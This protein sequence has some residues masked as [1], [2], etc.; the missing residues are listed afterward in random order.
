MPFSLIRILHYRLDRRHQNLRWLNVAHFF[1]KVASQLMS[2]YLPLFLYQLAQEWEPVDR[3]IVFGDTP[4]Q[5]G[6][7]MVSGFFLIERLTVLGLAIP[8]AKLAS[9]IGHSRRMIL[10]NLFLALSVMLLTYVRSHPWLLTLSAVVSGF[11]ICFFW[12]SYHTVITRS[13]SK[14]KLGRNLGATRFLSNFALMLVPLI[15][16]IAVTSLGYEYLFYLGVLMILISVTALLYL[17]LKP[18]KDEISWKE[19]RTWLKEK[20]FEQLVVSQAG[21][22]FNDMAIIIW[23]LYVFLLLG[24]VAR[25]GLVY[26][27]SLFV[28]MII[29]LFVGGFIDRSKNKKR[30]LFISGGLLSAV[31]ALRILTGQIWTIVFVDSLDRIIGNFHWL[32]FDKLM[33][34]RG[35]GSQAFSYFVYRSINQA[36]AGAIF[37][38]AL[39]IFFLFVPLGWKGVFLLGAGGVLLSLLIKESK[40]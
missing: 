9:I 32:F 26:T 7:V 30:P 22:Y 8:S 13:S 19:Y 18:E 34:S 1:R 10:G 33:M 20:S 15:G 28:A 5:E 11:Q 21:R 2:F 24:D 31:H 25:V 14:S 17:D 23:P 12:Q 27:I 16:G 36:M 37:W 3:L 38:G 29:D 35:S 6:I 40:D 4:L 39:L